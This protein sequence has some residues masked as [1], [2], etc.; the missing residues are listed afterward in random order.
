MEDAGFIL[1]S[2]IITAVG[3]AT[4]AVWVIRRGRKLAEH[5]TTEDMPWT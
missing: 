2:W 5:A 1:G 3:V 4:Y